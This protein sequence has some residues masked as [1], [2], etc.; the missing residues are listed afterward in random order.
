MQTFTGKFYVNEKKVEI[1][2]SNFI[3][4]IRIFLYKQHNKTQ[5]M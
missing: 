5:H 4:C 3:P 2:E 1:K